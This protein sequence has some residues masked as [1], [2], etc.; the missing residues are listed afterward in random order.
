V[1]NEIVINSLLVDAGL[2]GHWF[3]S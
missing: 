2:C 3:R 1:L